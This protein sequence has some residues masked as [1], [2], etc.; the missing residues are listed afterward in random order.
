MQ[1]VL[2]PEL[3]QLV[4]HQISSGKYQSAIEVISAAMRLLEQQESGEGQFQA[5]Q[6]EA[7]IG[8]EAAQRGELVDG[9]EAIRQIRASL[10]D[11]YSA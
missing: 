1:I 5:L 2:P 11:R 3:E 10:H 6:Q 9:M 4:Q 8:W 7:R